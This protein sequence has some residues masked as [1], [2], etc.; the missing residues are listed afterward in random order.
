MNKVMRAVLA[1]LLVLGDSVNELKEIIVQINDW[2][3][4]AMKIILMV[5]PAIR[6]L[7]L[8]LHTSLSFTYMM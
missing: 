4:S 3:M 1:A 7:L 6:H 8:I 2:T 5:V